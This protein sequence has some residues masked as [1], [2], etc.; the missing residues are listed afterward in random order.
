MTPA[1]CPCC[2]QAVVPS[3]LKLPKLKQRIFDVVQRHPGIDGEGLRTLVWAED[4]NGG[5]TCTTAIYVHINQLNRLLT[6][7]GIVVRGSRGGGYRITT[8]TVIPNGFA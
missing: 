4:P 1:R 5:P 3:G 8:S 7:H 6:P 2:G